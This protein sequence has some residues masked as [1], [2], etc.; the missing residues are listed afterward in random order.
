MA[1]I[2]YDEDVDMKILND[3]RIGVIGYGNQ[4]HAQAL[5]IRD[6]G[7]NPVIGNMEDE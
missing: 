7:F 6:S 3:Y 2:Y 4:G 5:N 1:K